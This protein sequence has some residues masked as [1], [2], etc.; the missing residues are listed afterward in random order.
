MGGGA[1]VLRQGREVA[2]VVRDEAGNGAGLL[3]TGVRRFGGDISSGGGLSGKGGAP[4]GP[5]WPAEI[6]VATQRDGSGRGQ[7]RRLRSSGGSRRVSSG[8]RC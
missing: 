6:P 3:V 1:P 7:L 4:A 2:V 8:T 5:W